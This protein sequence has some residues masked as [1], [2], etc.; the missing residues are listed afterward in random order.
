M[1]RTAVEKR[2]VRGA[3]A[4]TRRG[5]DLSFTRPPCDLF[6]RF[7]RPTV[8]VLLAVIALVEESLIVALKLV[9]EDD[10][11]NPTAVVAESLLGALVGAVDETVA[12]APAR[13]CSATSSDWRSTRSMAVLGSVPVHTRYPGTLWSSA[14]SSVIR[15]G[16]MNSFSRPA[17]TSRS[18]P[19][20][21]SSFK[22]TDA[23]CRFAIPAS[24]TLPMRL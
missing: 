18:T 5:R 11:S 3:A 9:V 23:V 21:H 16:W 13:F 2:R 17:F 20:A 14:V 22:Y 19:M 8:A 10:A 12:A 6:G 7:V 4:V 1:I 15:V 24:T